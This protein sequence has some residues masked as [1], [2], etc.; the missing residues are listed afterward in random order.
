[1]FS[2]E[3]NQSGS[4]LEI[5]IRRGDRDGP[6]IGE[7]TIDMLTVNNGGS[8]GYDVAEEWMYFKAGAYSQNNTGWANDFDQARFYRLEN[9]HSPNVDPAAG[10]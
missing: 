3:V 2:Y 4:E 6:I 5:I 7:L 9:S 10:Q 1:M 8:S